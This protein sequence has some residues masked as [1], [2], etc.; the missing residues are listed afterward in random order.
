MSITNLICNFLVLWGLILSVGIPCLVTYG[1]L[2]TKTDITDNDKSTAI[3]LVA[4]CSILVSTVIFQ[5]IVESVS[6]IFIYY[7][8]DKDMLER[9]LITERRIIQSTY[10]EI[11]RYSANPAMMDGNGPSGK[12]GYTYNRM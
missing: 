9:S 6:C 11:E 1:L 7:S 10:D 4:V 8:M 12:D 5:I 2:S 3:I